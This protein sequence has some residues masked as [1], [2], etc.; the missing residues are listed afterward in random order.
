MNIIIYFTEIVN[1]TDLSN[2]VQ[3]DSILHKILSKLS[4]LIDCPISMIQIQ[5]PV[6]LP[7]GVTIDRKAYDNLIGKKDPY[8]KTLVVGKV[9]VNRIFKDII[10]FLHEISDQ[11]NENKQEG[12]ALFTISND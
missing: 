5:N 9:V 8:D 12:I 2:E 10:E 6:I 7:S 3:R 1:S 11:I 4:E